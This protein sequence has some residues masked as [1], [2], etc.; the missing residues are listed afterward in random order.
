[1]AK[2]KKF[3][4]LKVMVHTEDGSV[5]IVNTS[6]CDKEISAS[7]MLFI[8]KHVAEFINIINGEIENGK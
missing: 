7:F 8:S 5:R 1:M 3:L 2:Y 4:G 6:K